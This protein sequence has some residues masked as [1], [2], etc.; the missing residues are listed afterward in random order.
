M[1]VVLGATAVVHLGIAPDR[2]IEPVVP[3]AMFVQV[4]RTVL[5]PSSCKEKEI[6]QFIYNGIPIYTSIQYQYSIIDVSDSI[7]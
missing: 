2:A 4:S 5:S 1:S 6:T 7:Q 3:L